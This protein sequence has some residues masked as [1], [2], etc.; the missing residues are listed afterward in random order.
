[1]RSIALNCV[2]GFSLALGLCSSALAQFGGSGFGG[3][4]FGGS[5]LGGSG[6]GGGGLGGGSSLGSTG[7]TDFVIKRN[8]SN[9]VGVNAVQVSG[10]SS[11]GYG[12]SMSSYGTMGGM[13]SRLGYGGTSA[14]GG[15]G[16]S[17]G[18]GGYGSSYG[19]SYGGYGGSASRG[20]GARYGF[21]P[22]QGLGGGA[23]A[24]PERAARELYATATMDPLGATLAAKL[25]G[26]KRI[27]FPVPLKVLFRGGGVILLG[28]V[29]TEHDRELAEQY[30]RLDPSVSEVENLLTLAGTARSEPAPAAAPQRAN[31]AQKTTPQPA[32]P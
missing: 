12:S 29:A 15:Y 16:G 13:R 9:F 28:Q 1:M 21:G 6:F 10:L 27:A 8:F 14:Y 11:S 22:A 32:T 7:S 24:V 31:P 17:G 30:L 18:Y 5:G 4:G 25:E 3:S 26:S 2:V 20:T 23:S 19:S